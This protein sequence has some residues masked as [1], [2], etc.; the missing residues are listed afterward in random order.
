MLVIILF[1]FKGD[2]PLEELKD[3]VKDGD[4]AGCMHMHVS[5][6]EARSFS[7]HPAPTLNVPRR[8][9]TLLQ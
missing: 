7:T 8:D 4:F 6:A 2:S 1:L 5:M 3:Y 9:S